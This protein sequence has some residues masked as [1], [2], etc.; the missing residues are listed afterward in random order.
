[1]KR[2]KGTA[3]AVLPKIVCCPLSVIHRQIPVSIFRIG[4]PAVN[5]DPCD[6]EDMDE[7][8]EMEKMEGIDGRS[9]NT[10]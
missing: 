4:K 8:E 6:L 3:K 7:M 2:L 1:M 9:L 10:M 5:G